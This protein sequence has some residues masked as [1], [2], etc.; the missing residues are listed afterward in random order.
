MDITEILKLCVSKNASDLHIAAKKPVMVRIDGLL[1]PLEEIMPFD[2]QAIFK[3]ITPLLSDKAITTL[4][5]QLE[6]DDSITL[7]NI[8]RF[9]LHLYYQLEGLSCAFRIIPKKIPTLDELQAP[10]VICQLLE[11]TSGLILVTG[12]TGSG[13]STTLAAM[14]NWL[15][16]NHQGHIITIEDPIEFIHKPNNCLINQR[17]VKVHTENFSC[18]LKASLRQD[19]DYILIGELRDLESIRLALTAAE[20]G[21]LVLATMHTHS[22]A[23]AID[24]LIHVFDSSEQAMIR[25]MLSESL[26]AVIAQKLVKQVTSGLV[27]AFEVLVATHAIKNLIRENKIPQMY[28]TMQMG[29]KDGMQTMQQSL[30]ALYK[31]GSISEIKL[32]RPY[33]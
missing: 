5:M 23:K 26:E 30:D 32:N 27:A 9:R 14:I 6:Y 19:P 21:H 7:E 16:Q 17:Q 12:A 18:A 20:T 3:L 4:K 22:A 8:G 11:K 15:N 28:S 31:A 2:S 24:R 10:K 29:K 33:M 13:K 25:M 1:L